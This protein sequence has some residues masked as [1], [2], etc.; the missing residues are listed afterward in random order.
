MFDLMLHPINGKTYHKPYQR[1]EW[2][3]I[4]Q[5]YVKS[6]KT[7]HIILHFLL[8]IIPMEELR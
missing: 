7:S 4:F 8:Q 5:V 1:I 6:L 3:K 2:Q